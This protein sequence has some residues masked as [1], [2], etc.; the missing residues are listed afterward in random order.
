MTS[1]ERNAL[2]SDLVGLASDVADANRE[3]LYNAEGL[4]DRLHEL[5]TLHDKRAAQL[6]SFLAY[7]LRKAKS[8]G[9]SDR[10]V[11]MEVLAECERLG[12]TKSQKA[13]NST[14]SSER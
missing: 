3:L 2:R 1:K 14:A 12:L 13:K 8:K 7:L 11:Y 10:A 9:V 4:L 5:E 6:G